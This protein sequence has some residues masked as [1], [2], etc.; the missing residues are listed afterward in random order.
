[1]AK[2]RN[3]VPKRI[4]GVKVPKP[5]RRGLKDLAKSQNGKTVIAEALV[6]A[7]ALLAA[8]EARPGSKTRR[9][10]AAAGRKLKPA[11]VA[12]TAAAVEGRAN[13]A[14][15]FEHATRS[16]TDA[17]RKPRAVSNNEPPPA[18]H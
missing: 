13:V 7:G 2:K 15:A 9:G 4:A 6:A 3:K 12:A 5:V 1:M 17:L 14:A 10:A 11:A 16:F 8:V 18:A